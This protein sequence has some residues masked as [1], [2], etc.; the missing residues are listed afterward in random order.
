MFI[1]LSAQ[2]RISIVTSTGTSGY[3]PWDPTHASCPLIN[4]YMHKPP[5]NSVDLMLQW[6]SKNRRR[7]HLIQG[8]IQPYPHPRSDLILGLDH[9]LGCQVIKRPQLIFSPPGV[10]GRVWRV[11][12]VEWQG[13][14]WRDVH[15]VAR[16]Q[17]PE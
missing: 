14:E 12:G 4:T 6:L 8:P 17:G 3:I 7:A 5:L 10:P 1:G 15:G 2:A 13:G 9:H 11:R 16:I